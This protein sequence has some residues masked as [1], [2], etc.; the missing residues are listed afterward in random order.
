MLIELYIYIYIYV[1]IC[2]HLVHLVHACFQQDVCY[3]KNN[4]VFT[5]EKILFS[6]ILLLLP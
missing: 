4:V 3:I 5:K 6:T 1:Q 2:M